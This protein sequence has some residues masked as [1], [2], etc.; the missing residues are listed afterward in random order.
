MELDSESAADKDRLSSTST[1][2]NQLESYL[3]YSDVGN[4][5]DYTRRYQN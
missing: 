2:P 3:D 1:I 5:R 4:I